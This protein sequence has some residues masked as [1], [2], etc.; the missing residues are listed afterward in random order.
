VP[1]YVAAPLST[2]DLATPDGEAIP[3]EE[4]GRAEL[5]RVGDTE[6]LPD[7]VPVRHPAFDVTPY[8]LIAGIITE[9]GV[10]RAPYTGSL[11]EQ[12]EAARAAR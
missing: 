5:A 6:I 12:V 1:F 9:R 3:I 2:V 11:R 4:R 8:A 10:A 7:G